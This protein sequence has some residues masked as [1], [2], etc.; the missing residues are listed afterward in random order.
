MEM[1]FPLTASDVAWE[2][3]FA[4]L[5]QVRLRTGR[6]LPPAES[7]LAVWLAAQRRLAASG[8]LEA[9]REERL[10]TLGVFAKDVAVAASE[11]LGGGKVG[12][13]HSREDPLI[14]SGIVADPNPFS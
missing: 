9:I 3:M 10:E 13:G 6:C 7:R 14:S 2:R 4:E 12:S 8:E 11:M 5:Q 1:G